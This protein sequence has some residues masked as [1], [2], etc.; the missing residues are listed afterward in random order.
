MNLADITK[1]MLLAGLLSI[2]ATSITFA[3][4]NQEFESGSR[5]EEAN[6]CWFFL[7]FDVKPRPNNFNEATF[8]E[9]VGRS[10]QLPD[11][12]QGSRILATP[13]ISFDG[14]GT[15]QFV[16][17]MNSLSTELEIYTYEKDAADTIKVATITSTPTAANESIGITWSGVHKII[18]RA[19]PKPNYFQR[20]LFIDNIVIDGEDVADRSTNPGNGLCDCIP[21]N[22]NQDPIANDDTGIDITNST[23]AII[24]VLLNDSDPDDDALTITSV[25]TT[26][27]N[28]T[29]RI[30]NKQIEYTA[31]D[32]YTG[33]DS[34]T[35][36]IEDGQGGQAT[37][38]VTVNVLKGNTQPTVSTVTLTSQED[39]VVYFTQQDFEDSY[40]DADQDP[41]TEIIIISLPNDGVLLLGSD[42]VQIG[43]RVALVDTERLMFIPENN[44]F[45]EATFQWNG[46]DGTSYADQGDQVIITIVPVN[47]TPVAQN[48]EMTTIAQQIVTDNLLK[49][50][51]DIEQDALTI[52]TTLVEKPQGTVTIQ[53]DGSYTYQASLGFFGTDTF[54]YELCDAGNPSA[55][56]EAT[57]TILVE[58][59]PLAISEGFS[60]NGDDNNEAW[61]IRGIEFF[62]SNVV[63]VFNRWGNLVY[64]ANGYDNVNERW[65]GRATRGLVV[66]DSELPFGTYYYTIDLG[67]GSK[68]RKGYL[69]LQR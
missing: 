64:R 15:I 29:V 54:M 56:T 22:N 13:W 52:S 28:G 60:P 61:Y 27:T 43:D 47:D 21:M 11:N 33:T 23:T 63:S 50:A 5:G 3:Q 32:N 31:N 42:T 57:V 41:L 66:S 65:D 49:Y 62:P 14:S 19:I 69:V 12:I 45:G 17:R 59:M 25:N 53:P 67:D 55:C 37:A 8:G 36:T 6:D 46:S 18:F 20:R 51:S 7:G 1:T 4:V 16:H 24:D 35:Y 58:K 30:V 26:T 38:T 48:S 2:A 10:Q 9:H 39:Q 68:L 34:F 44:F 40:Q